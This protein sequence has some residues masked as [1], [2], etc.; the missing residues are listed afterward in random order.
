MMSI[1]H[2]I[3][4]EANDKSIV[5]FNGT[6][7]TNEDEVEPSGIYF[8]EH[9]N[10]VVGNRKRAETFYCDGLG[11]RL[12]PIKVNTNVSFH[13]NLGQQQFHLVEEGAE[14]CTGHGLP[15]IKTNKIFGNIGIVVPS[16][17]NVCEKL[18]QLP[19]KYERV[20]P[21]GAVEQS[22]KRREEEKIH[23]EYA[24]T[25]IRVTCP[26][27]NVFYVYGLKE[28]KTWIAMK[29]PNQ[30]TNMNHLRF[31]NPVGVRGMMPGIRFFEFYVDKGKAK[32]IGNFYQKFLGCIVEFRSVV[33]E[34][35][36]NECTLVEVGPNIHL[37]FSEVDKHSG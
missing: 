27:G 31:Q 1:I 19:F 2:K 5:K 14:D 17:L 37:A 24:V 7:A 6:N 25:S 3:I 16:L 23:N 8:M 10:L 9:M 11:F 33:I 12:D 28:N 34:G 35:N 26:W 36:I 21:Q 4:T 32:G 20:Y 22:Q 30:L 13:I 29:I 18:D 15:G